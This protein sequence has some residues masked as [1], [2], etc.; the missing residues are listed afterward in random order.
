MTYFKNPQSF[1]TATLGKSIDVDGAYGAQCWDLFAFFCQ[2]EG[3]NV[4]TYCSLT[5]YAGDLYKKRYEKNYDKYFEFFYPHHAVRGDWIFWDQHVAMV[6]DVD[7]SHDR[8]N[9]LGQNQGGI[10]R[11]TFKEYKLSS[12]LG[13]MR[14]IPWIEKETDVLYG[15]DI[16]NWQSSMDLKSVLAKTNTSFVIAKATEGTDFNDKYCERFLDP[17]LAAGKKIGFYHFA[18]PEKF[19]AKDEAEFFYNKVKNYIGKGIPILDWESSGKSNVKWAK[20]WL[21]YIYAKTKVK[22][23]IYMSESVVNSYNW[24]SVADAGYPLWVAKYR[25][26]IEDL[27]YD[28]SNAGSKPVVNYWTSY[29]MWQWTSSGKLSGY[30]GKLDCNVF[31]GDLSKWNKLPGAGM[32]GW[33]KSGSYWYY[34]RNGKKLTGWQKLEWSKG[35]NWFYFNSDGIMISDGLYSIA[36]SGGRDWFLF[37]S[38]GCMLTGN[39]DV[40]LIFDSNGCLTGGKL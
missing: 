3:L 5:G 40:R 39:H 38:N 25:D 27:N 23:M 17:A 16:S 37:D 7:I 29:V 11:V 10:K 32:E 13:C 18:R 2:K 24:S 20:E 1:N 8:V 33:K 35:T 4:N 14:Y 36:W 22:P 9:C 19:A 28:M 21:D 30:S 15:I 6:W 34:Y 31:Y 12:A 26:N